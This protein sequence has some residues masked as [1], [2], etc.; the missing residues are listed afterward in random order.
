MMITTILLNGTL[1]LA[2]VIMFCFC[3]TDLET[4]ILE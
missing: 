1:G 4:Q 3:I 2:M